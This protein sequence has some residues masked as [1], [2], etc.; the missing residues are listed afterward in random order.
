MT[1]FLQ[2]KKEFQGEKGAYHIFPQLCKGC[3]LCK[4]KCPH[5]VLDWA[6]TLGLY[7]TPIM[8]PA[9]MERCTA[10]RICETVCPECAILIVRKK[11]AGKKEKTPA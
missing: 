1:E 8:E 10:C 5:Q 11:K 3:G 6:D 7:G 2:E 4:E 9:A